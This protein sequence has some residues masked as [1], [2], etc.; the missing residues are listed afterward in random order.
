MAFVHETF[1]S[2]IIPNF[3]YVG[4]SVHGSQLSILTKLGITFVLNISNEDYRN[5]FPS[6]C[7][8][9]FLL[10]SIKDH[11]KESIKDYFD[12]SFEFIEKAR[13]INKKVLIHCGEGRSRSCA[14]TIAYLMKYRK[15]NLKQSLLY[16]KEKRE[17]TDPNNGFMRQ[18][19]ELE[20]EL[21]GKSSV[22]SFL[23]EDDW[24]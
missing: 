10:I 22:D 5:R 14:L 23:F 13:L 20:I 2:E 12:S 15:V 4:N 7:G 21:F 24:G 18:L 6:N 11:P 9:E 17:E 1:P 19:Q 16:L 8:I 3:L